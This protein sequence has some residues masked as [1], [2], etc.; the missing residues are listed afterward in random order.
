MDQVLLE[1]QKVALLVV[2]RGAYLGA[3]CNL[4]FEEFQYIF[5]D[6]G[7]ILALS[8]LQIIYEFYYFFLI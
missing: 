2:L 3:V 6:R 5:E 1:N 8:S 7:I 4:V